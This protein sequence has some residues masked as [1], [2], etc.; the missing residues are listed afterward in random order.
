MAKGGRPMG[1]GTRWKGM[2]AI[3]NIEKIFHAKEKH[4]IDIEFFPLF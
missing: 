4:I 1:S 3:V 2:A